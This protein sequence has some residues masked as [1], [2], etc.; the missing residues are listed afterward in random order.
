[1]VLV[2]VNPEGIPDY[3]TERPQW[4]VW[5]IEKRDGKPTKVPYDATTDKQASTTD[6]MTWVGF[7]QAINAYEEGGYDG[8]VY[9]GVGFVLSSGDPFVG[10]DFDDCRNPDTGEVDPDVAAIVARFGHR[11]VEVSPSGTGLHLITRG[12]FKGGKRSG[13]MEMYGQDRFFTITG[14]SPDA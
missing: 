5:R 11:Y 2:E 8:G 1:M 10:I 7:W 9:H 4:V 3:L 13:K 12:S 14:V 6:L